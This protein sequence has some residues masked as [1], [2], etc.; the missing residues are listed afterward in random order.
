MH[1]VPTAL[2]PTC[3]ECPVCNTRRFGTD[4]ATDTLA[5]R[6]ETIRALRKENAELKAKLESSTKTWVWKE[7]PHNRD[8]WYLASPDSPGD[9][10][11][12][13]T[14]DGIYYDWGTNAD[15]GSVSR[16]DV[17]K[18]VDVLILVENAA[19]ELRPCDI[20]IRPDGVPR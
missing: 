10:V 17:N 4:A 8:H 9:V 12:H 14:Y 20:V 3:Y 6:D 19:P 15:D 1:T 11:G 16:T 2:P 7:A 18:L 13:V 5:D